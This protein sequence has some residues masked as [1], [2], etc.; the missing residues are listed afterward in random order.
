MRL[1]HVKGAAEKIR[2]HPEL[3]VSLKRDESVRLNDVFKHKRPLH[4]EIGS[5]KG[6][7]IHTLA[8][9]HPDINFIAIEK[10]DSA[11]V[12]LLDKQRLAPLDNLFL[13]RMDAE[14]ISACFEPKSIA[15]IYLNFSDPWP[16]ARHEKRRLTHPD[17]LSHYKALLTA[18]GTIALK[19]DNRK[20]FEY[21]LL[22]M[23]ETNMTIHELSLDL[24]NDPDMDNIRTEFEEKYGKHGPIYKLISTF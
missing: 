18:H 22:S 11:I 16:K 24:H 20:F 6:R 13:V 10:F 3:I 15:C 1:R 5:G 2:N 8:T 19:T 4:V 7:F 9:K 12:K 23:L 17:F 14:Q 21:S